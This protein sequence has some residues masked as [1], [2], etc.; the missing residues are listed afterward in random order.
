MKLDYKEVINR[1]IETLEN[2]PDKWIINP[3]WA[4]TSIENTNIEIW[5]GNGFL[6]LH[7]EYPFSIPLSFYSKYRLYKAINQCKYKKLK[8]VLNKIGNE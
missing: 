3:Y 2:N 1:L 5:I 6:L 4:K 7:F 8:Q